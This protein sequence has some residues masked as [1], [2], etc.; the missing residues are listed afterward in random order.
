MTRNNHYIY[1][2]P[3]YLFDKF[4]GYFKGETY[5]VSDKKALSNLRAQYCKKQGK[6]YN[7]K[8]ILDEKGLDL[9]Y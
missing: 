3:V 5:A 2:G 1:D 8:Y 4:I 7:T 9:V 6:A